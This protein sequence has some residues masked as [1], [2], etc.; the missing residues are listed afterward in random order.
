MAAHADA[1][2]LGT[3]HHDGGV[4]AQVVAVAALELL[5]AGELGLLVGGQS[6][7][8]VDWACAH[9]LGYDPTQIPIAREAYGRFQW[10]LTSFPAS[11]VRLVGDL[12]DGSA[13]EI[14]ARREIPGPVAYPLGW[15]DAVAPHRRRNGEAVAAPGGAPS[16]A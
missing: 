12:G 11:A 13:D 10:P 1:L 9:L 5:V 3:L 8:A 7:A 14:L 16:E 6:S 15:L 4:P 2:A